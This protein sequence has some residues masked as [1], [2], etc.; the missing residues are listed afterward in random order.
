MITVF[1][2]VGNEGFALPMVQA[3]PIDPNVSQA[4]VWDPLNLALNYG[5]FA[6]NSLGD[7][8]VARDLAVTRNAAIAGTLA[9]T[10]VS[11]FTGG[12]KL[13]GG[14]TVT[15]NSLEINSTNVNLTG[16][17]T[18]AVRLA[19]DNL[20]NN[21]DIV[22]TGLRVQGIAVVGSRKTG[23]TAMTGTPQ[24]GTFATGSVTLPQ[25]A[26]VVM[27]LQADLIAHGLIGT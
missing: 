23:W 25:L 27:A 6:I 2:S 3:Y 15:D 13:E 21:C 8:T 14:I 22:P 26:G 16:T 5:P 20:T 10:G 17:L 18:S 7:F 1:G 19:V 24:K 9:V 11:T 4:L 12:V